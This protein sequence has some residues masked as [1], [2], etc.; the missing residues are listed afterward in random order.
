[1]IKRTEYQVVVQE[2]VFIGQLEPVQAARSS[3]FVEELDVV[4]RLAVGVYFTDDDFV[5]A[6]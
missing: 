3:S 4:R 2:S 6:T 5:Q 1:M